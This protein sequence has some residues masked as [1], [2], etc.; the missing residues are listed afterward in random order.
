MRH[1]GCVILLAA[2]L[3][4]T[5]PAFADTRVNETCHASFFECFNRSL[6]Q[7]RRKVGLEGSQ[8]TP[9]PAKPAQTAPVKPVA[10]PPGSTTAL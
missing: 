5:T 6:D 7:V 10:I 1:L 9:K 2:I 3:P 8:K 4:I